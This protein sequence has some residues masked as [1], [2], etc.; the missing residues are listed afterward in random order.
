M[1]V[2]DE[3]PDFAAA[4]DTDVIRQAKPLEEVLS[5]KL[6]TTVQTSQLESRLRFVDRVL[7]LY[8]NHAV[9]MQHKDHMDGKM[10]NAEY[11]IAMRKV[12]EAIYVAATAALRSTDLDANA[13]IT[14][15]LTSLKVGERWAPAADTREV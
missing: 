12:T 13:T 5:L 2:R 1:L 10:P 15:I 3:P 9:F 4:H 7:A 11:K 6:A 8:L 14:E